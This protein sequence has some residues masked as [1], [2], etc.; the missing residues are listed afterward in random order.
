MNKRIISEKMKL[1]LTDPK[2]LNGSVCKEIM[3]LVVVYVRRS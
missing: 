2:H 1:N 3:H